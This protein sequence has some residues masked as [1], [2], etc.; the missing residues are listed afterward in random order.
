MTTGYSNL[1]IK[2]R[3]NII[4]GELETYRLD[5]FTRTLDKNQGRNKG[6][7]LPF[8][9]GLRFS[10][11]LIYEI[12]KTLNGTPLKVTWGHILDEHGAYCSSE[13]DII[14]YKGGF[15]TQW[16]GNGSDCVMDFR[17]IE[18]KNAIAVISCKSFLKKA[19]IEK[20]YCTNM[21]N[22]VDK[23]W[24]FAEC[25]EPLSSKRIETATKSIGYEHY[26]HLYTWDRKTDDTY[27]C[28]DKWKHFIDTVK[29]LA[30]TV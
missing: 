4:K 21:K 20:E 2:Q 23:V 24:L 19:K 30:E 29:E 12:R 17:F 15:H 10:A 11:L 18:K 8:I 9:R 25:C 7:I 1:L 16:N 27:D 26:W 5:D 6:A 22:F 14:I 3:Y 13:C 28:L